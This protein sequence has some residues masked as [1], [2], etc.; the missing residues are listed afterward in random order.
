MRTDAFP[1]FLFTYYFD[2]RRRPIP[3]HSCKFFY[4][5]ILTEHPQYFPSFKNNFFFLLDN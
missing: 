3:S 2:V 1:H 5:L 4:E